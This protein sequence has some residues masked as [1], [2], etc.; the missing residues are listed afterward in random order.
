VSY[1]VELETLPIDH[2]SHITQGLD[3]TTFAGGENG[4]CVQLTFRGFS[5]QFVQ[6]DGAQLER[7]RAVLDHAQGA[8]L[9]SWPRGSY[10]RESALNAEVSQLRGELR[11]FA[12]LVDR[13]MR[14]V[15][16]DTDD[17][18]IMEFI[19]RY[20]AGETPVVCPECDIMPP[21]ANGN[22]G[23]CAR[24]VADSAERSA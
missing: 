20:S 4:R 6:L 9:E 18:T 10:S 12:T 2:E 11:N 23:E 7:L 14:G 21:G 15:G 19:D 24:I 16:A 1:S 22:C 17:A 3:V 8:S 5:S 13:G